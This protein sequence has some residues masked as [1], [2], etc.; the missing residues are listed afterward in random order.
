[1][2]DVTWRM[3]A[4]TAETKNVPLTSVDFLEGWDTQSI[5]LTSPTK[6]W[7]HLST[8]DWY[9]KDKYVLD[10]VF[11]W[12]TTFCCIYTMTFAKS[13]AFDLV[14]SAILIQTK[15]NNLVKY[16]GLDTVFW[17][18]QLLAFTPECVYLIFFFCHS[19]EITCGWEQHWLLDKEEQCLRGFC[20]SHVCF[21]KSVSGTAAVLYFS[22]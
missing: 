22:D 5:S 15:A 1:M 10:D 2:L 20:A 12:Y 19:C 11:K 14:G 13:S 7:G 17:G 3:V 21:V 8:S 4:G 9:W 18:L 6:T 16:M